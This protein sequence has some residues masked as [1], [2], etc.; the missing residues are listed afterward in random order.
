MIRYATVRTE[1]A[2]T[3]DTTWVDDLVMGWFGP[4]GPCRIQVVLDCRFADARLVL[5]RAEHEE[6]LA[7]G[8][9]ADVVHTEKWQLYE[10]D[11][12]ALQWRALTQGIAAISEVGEL[13]IEVLKSQFAS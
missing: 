12:I 3:S 8:I 7:S 2:E 11:E 10:G 4:P 13:T 5:R 6:I 1:R 9:A